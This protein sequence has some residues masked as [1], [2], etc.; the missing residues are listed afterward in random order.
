M[1]ERKLSYKV[2]VD[3]GSAVRDLERLGAAGGDAGRDI[4]QGFDQAKSASEQ[5]LSALSAKL[6]QVEAD[7]RGT[8]SAVAAIKAEL[9]VAVDDDK[10][11]QF[12]SDLKNKMGVAFDAVEADAKEF[13]DVLG[14]GVDMSKTVN[15]IHGVGDAL[16]T[17]KG[18]ADQSR[19]VFANM[20]G[21]TTQDL[22]ELGGVVGTLG[23]GM[24]QLGE[25]AADG[26]ISLKGLAGMAG[27]MALLAAAGA[28]V[29]SVMKNIA[30]TKAFNVDQIKSMSDA[31]G[32]LGDTSLALRESLD[33]VFNARVDDDSIWG[34]LTGGQKTED[35]ADDLATVGVSLRDID[36]IIRSGATDRESWELLPDVQNLDRVLQTAGVSV[37]Q[38]GRIMDG[39][40]ESTINWTTATKGA[41]A[42]AEFFATSLADINEIIRA[43][44]MAESPLAR[45]DWGLYVSEIDG[46]RYDLKAI[47]N[48]VV[49]DMADGG[50]EF[51]STAGN[52]DI[53][54]EALRMS[55]PDVVALA[56]E[57]TS[58]T[59][60][61]GDLATATRDTVD[62]EAEA[63]KA[64]QETTDALHGERDAIQELID[65]E[66]GRIDSAVTFADAQQDLR[67]ASAALPGMF[68]ETGAVINDTGASIE[69]VTAAIQTQRGETEA[70]IDG[71]VETR[72]KWAE[73]NGV[74]RTGAERVAD[75][76]EAL[77]QV[78]GQVDDD[79]IPALAE[80]YSNILKIPRSKQTEFETVLLR[81]DQDEIEAFIAANSGTK[82][83]AIKV[84]A[85]EAELKSIDAEIQA[86]GD[87]AQATVQVD[88]NT[89]PAAD[90]IGYFRRQEG[91][92]ALAVPAKA[93]TASADATM[94]AWRKTQANTPV[95]VTIK[96]ANAVQVHTTPVYGKAGPTATATAAPTATTT[97]GGGGSVM[98]AAP[99][100]T[101][102]NVTI[103]AGVIG[104]RWDVTRNVVK[105]VNDAH[106]LGRL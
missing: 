86:V 46:A 13:A 1:P 62:A 88:A 71:V 17:T 42:S 54:A 7:A 75:Y 91:A 90:D 39:V 10:I 67:D 65:A 40:F 61:A 18:H 102:L 23:V 8:A 11:T 28:G 20:V 82:D 50:A 9:T 53:L 37:D 106:R 93:N 32:E 12:V 4:A 36:Q 3:T 84:S 47:W 16:D 95:Y 92:R 77:G 76:A 57:Q 30:E 96:A 5:A 72:D 87:G 52:V 56:R 64:A 22:G 79:V 51:D 34:Q 38:Y 60:T 89:A 101:N 100:I 33:G 25:Y 45:L 70:W 29:Q 73:T 48:D 44:D 97:G 21:N 15:E 49:R 19:S 41:Q 35:L 85:Q 31:F 103:Q 6:D 74:V 58:A 14:R 83:L 78:A 2:D 105:A 24:G 26:T 94:S 104:N 98:V 81:G 27:P 66:Q 55:V 80:Y 99:P 63:T 59:K 68:A 69:D 43:E